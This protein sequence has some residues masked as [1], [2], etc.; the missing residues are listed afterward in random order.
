MAHVSAAAFIKPLLNTCSGPGTVLGSGD[1]E[2]P[3]RVPEGGLP[4]S[5]SIWKYL[6]FSPESSLRFPLV[7]A[8]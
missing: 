1:T 2:E 6:C 5:E 4:H 7:G 3:D 8:A